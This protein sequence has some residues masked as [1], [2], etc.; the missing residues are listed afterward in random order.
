M[1]AYTHFFVGILIQ[2]ALRGVAPIWLRVLLVIILSFL[3]HFPVDVLAKMTYHPPEARPKDPFWVGYHLYVLVM[4]IVVLVVFW[5]NYWVAILSAVLVD[6]YDWVAL[7]GIRA[8]K[9]NPE[10]GKG[11]Q[12]HEIIDRIRERWFTWMPDW[13][14]KRRGII[15]EIIIVVVFLIFFVLI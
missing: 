8:I 12:I 2:Y 9:K 10:W 3:S 7:R 6:L 14:Y 11:W 5:G 15:P 13:N 1:Q 4:T